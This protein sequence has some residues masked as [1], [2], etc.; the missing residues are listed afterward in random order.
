M[1]TTLKRPRDVNQLAKLIAEIAI[2][3]ADDSKSDDGKNSAAVALGRKGGLKGGKARAE[4]LTPE[5]RTE[6]A[7]NAA[8]ARWSGTTE[9]HASD[10]PSVP[11][12]QR[13]VLKTPPGTG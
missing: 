7:K 11:A 5:R 2:G 8:A 10:E 9:Q 1:G 6:I 3:Q 12:P 13:R 4:L